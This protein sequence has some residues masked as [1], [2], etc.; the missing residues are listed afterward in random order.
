MLLEYYIYNAT[1][2]LIL[3]NSLLTSNKITAS[4]E[5]S[6]KISRFEQKET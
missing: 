1:F 4:V 5:E 2:L 6:S 3:S